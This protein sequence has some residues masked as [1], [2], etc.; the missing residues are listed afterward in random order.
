[1]YESI[2][3]AFL[4]GLATIISPCPF[5]SDITAV[6]YISRDVSSRKRV[7]GNGISYG[8]GKLTAYFGLSLLFIFGVQIRPIQSFLEHYG[9]PALGPFFIICAIV[10]SYMGYREGHHE[11]H[12]NH[13]HSYIA[14][15]QA[16]IPNG[17]AVGAF[18][19]GLCG[20]LAFCPY[21]GVLYFGMMIP[22]AVSQ[23]LATGWLVP[24]SFGI[25]TALPVLAIAVVIA[26]GFGS[27]GALTRH[28]GKVE[29]WL[30]WFCVVLF[31][32]MG[33]YLSVGIFS[34]HHHHH[35]ENIHEHQTVSTVP[36]F[37]LFSEHY[38]CSFTVREKCP[39][40]GR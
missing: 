25:A 18:V 29:V 15:V 11:H 32:A 9:E 14:K 30:R 21:S 35:H 5:C 33:V 16:H 17:S 26:Y 22:L 40:L 39:F 13:D 24:L 4:L 2:I 10:M 20:S 3:S 28:L 31:F 34:G 8:I 1:M 12:H 37:R 27:I 36:T 7:I 23:P 38:L 19:I 6:S